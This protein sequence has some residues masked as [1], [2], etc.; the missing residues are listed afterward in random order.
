MRVQSR[1]LVTRMVSCKVLVSHVSCVFS[2]EYLS[3][4]C[5]DQSKVPVTNFSCSV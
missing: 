2:L 4:N 5:V 3:L 1:V